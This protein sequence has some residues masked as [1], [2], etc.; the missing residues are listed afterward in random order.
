MSEIESSVPIAGTSCVIK[1]GAICPFFYYSFFK[2]LLIDS[3]MNSTLELYPPFFKI[4]SISFISS[5][6]IEIFL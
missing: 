6:G 4:L 1:C 5:V 2:F 3:F